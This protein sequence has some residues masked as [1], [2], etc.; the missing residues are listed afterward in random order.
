MRL[1][2]D[3][4]VGS[5]DLGLSWKKKRGKLKVITNQSIIN[6]F[7]HEHW[8]VTERLQLLSCNYRHTYNNM[9]L[10]IAPS[11]TSN[12]LSS[13]ICI[14][15]M[16]SYLD[17]WKMDYLFSFFSFSFPHLA[18]KLK[19]RRWQTSSKM[20]LLL[21][22][23]TILLKLN[24]NVPF[25]LVTCYMNVQYIHYLNSNMVQLHWNDGGP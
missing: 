1:V 5:W 21:L 25:V 15:N 6:T 13:Y 14:K 12:Y 22:E 23:Y 3:P 7:A 4:L 9:S 10:Q 19:K 16:V 18:L 8:G 2:S 24:D 17:K 20:L 11:R